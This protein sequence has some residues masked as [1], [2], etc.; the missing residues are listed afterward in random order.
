VFENNVH[1]QYPNTNVERLNSQEGTHLI[2]PPALLLD[3]VLLSLFSMD[4]APHFALSFTVSGGSSLLIV[5]D[6]VI[7]G[8]LELIETRK[9]RHGGIKMGIAEGWRMEVGVSIV[10]RRAIASMGSQIGSPRGDIDCPMAQS[11]ETDWSRVIGL[12]GETL[13]SKG[14]GSGPPWWCTPTD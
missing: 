5:V 8:V 10:E 13:H 12:F 11:D 4:L 14:R 2:A 1:D 9:D 7:Q 6:D 3:L